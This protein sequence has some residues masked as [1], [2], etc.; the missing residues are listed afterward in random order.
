MLITWYMIGEM[1]NEAI[2][3]CF[4]CV[5]DAQSSDTYRCCRQEFE[6]YLFGRKEVGQESEDFEPYSN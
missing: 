3:S 6:E 1:L 2:S 5:H 4:S